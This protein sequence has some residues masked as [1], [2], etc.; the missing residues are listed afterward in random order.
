MAGFE[1]G[2]RSS[3]PAV[4][5]LSFFGPYISPLFFRQIGIDPGRSNIVIVFP[6]F[7]SAVVE[8]QQSLSLAGFALA[9]GAMCH[10]LEFL[11][12]LNFYF[13]TLELLN[14]IQFPTLFPTKND[15]SYAYP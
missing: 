10:R 15:V 4:V 5:S 13:R 7:R 1:L 9:A 8:Y 3:R 14:I 2:S 11:F 6:P 12:G